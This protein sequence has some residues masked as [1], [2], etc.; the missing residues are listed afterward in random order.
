MFI[1]MRPLARLPTTSDR[2]RPT[3]IL[4]QNILQKR[5]PYKFMVCGATL[6]RPHCWT[7]ATT[8][9]PVELSMKLRSRSETHVVG[10]KLLTVHRSAAADVGHN[11]RKQ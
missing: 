7:A 8:A 3:D 10:I 1:D 9:A 11:G 2:P 4:L 5:L 6:T